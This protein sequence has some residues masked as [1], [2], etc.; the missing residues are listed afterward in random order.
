ML[1]LR[2]LSCRFAHRL[3]ADRNG[4]RIREVFRYE[5]P[6]IPVLNTFRVPVFNFSIVVSF[7]FTT[8]N[9]YRF[10]SHALQGI[11][12]GVD[13][14]GFRVVNKI[15]S[16]AHVPP[17]PTDVPLPLKSERAFRMF[18]LAMPARFAEIPAAKELYRLC[19]PVRA[20]SS[21]LH[22]EGN[23]FGDFH[24]VIFYVCNRSIL[25]TAAKGYK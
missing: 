3:P 10:G 8:E 23:R 18:S 22:V 19:C 15:N 2:H 14:R 12:A 24:F 9:Q 11:P 1:L 4:R 16:A 20:S 5:V 13:I 7:I 25:F 17:F 21:L 6:D